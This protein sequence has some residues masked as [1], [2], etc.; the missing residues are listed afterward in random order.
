MNIPTKQTTII[1]SMPHKNVQEAYDLLNRYA[2]SIP[3]WPQLPRRSFKEAMIPQFSEGFPGIKV[4]EANS[5]FWVEKDE[6]LLDSLT[7]FFENVLS[8]N[9]DAFSVSEEYAEG[10]HYFL[11][12]LS[13]GN[14]RLPLIKGHVT[15]PFTFGLGLNDNNRKPVWFDEQYR[16]VVLN[17]L[18]M[19]ASWQIR[20][21]RK[22]S[23]NVIIFFD[24]PILSALG[25]PAY[26]G[27][28]GD[29]VTRALNELIDSVHTMDAVAGVHCCGN[30]D[31]AI[32]LATRLDI[33]SFDAYF[34]GEKL[35]LYSEEIKGFL[36]RGGFLAW[37]MI[38]NIAKNLKQENAHSLKDRFQRL[39][40]KFV[41]NGMGEEQIYTH[42]LLTPS[43]GMGT[44][45][46]DEFKLLLELLYDFSH[47]IEL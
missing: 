10:L 37:G 42:M 17:G 7:L 36:E 40:E 18:R 16:E 30:M 33:I 46:T 44:L 12:E 13:V 39:I 29:D 43:C 19:K 34:Y 1:G 3:T 27:I 5:R 41:D 15:G 22:Y 21:L 28:Q 26:L 8:E 4:D 32:L 6:N 25:T 47:L 9:L 45:S 2:P 11:Q 20:E 14:A 38:P 31:W 24:E 23:D 35:A